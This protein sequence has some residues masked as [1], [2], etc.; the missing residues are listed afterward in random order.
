MIL[1]KV[2]EQVGKIQIKSITDSLF[3]YGIY[4]FALATISGVFKTDTWITILLFSV[5]GLFEFIGLGFYIYFAKKI[6]I[7][8]VRK[9]FS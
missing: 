9:V 1:T 5:G 7:T 3:K 8:Y 4:I 6:Q 2:L